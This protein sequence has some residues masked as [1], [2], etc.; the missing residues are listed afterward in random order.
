MELEKGGPS[1]NNV[2]SAR[3]LRG[4]KGPSERQQVSGQEKGNE[5]G[6][7]SQERGYLTGAQLVSRS[8]LADESNMLE[9]E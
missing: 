2:P 8:L 5:W 3:N 9:E 7:L 4:E 1:L 6:Q